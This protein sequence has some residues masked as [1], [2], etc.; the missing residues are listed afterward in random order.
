[1]L[2]YIRPLP[3]VPERESL[4]YVDDIFVEKH[5]PEIRYVLNQLR[6]VDV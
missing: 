6:E 1:M 3:D 2:F 5:I 4:T